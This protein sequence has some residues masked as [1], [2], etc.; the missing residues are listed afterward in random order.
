MQLHISHCLT[1]RLTTANN[2]DAVP[3][4]AD[5][6]GRVVAVS[7]ALLGHGPLSV[8][9]FATL[10]AVGGFAPYFFFGGLVLSAQRT[11]TLGGLSD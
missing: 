3:P 10:L 8:T 2:L 5:T 1:G 11:A 4:P 9:T 6:R 7:S